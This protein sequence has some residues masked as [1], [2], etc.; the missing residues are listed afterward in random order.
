MSGKNFLGVDLPIVQAP[1]AGIQDQAL[2]IAVS[3]AGGLGSLPCAM[4]SAGKMREQLSI[5]RSETDRPLNTNFFCHNSPELSKAREFKWR[6]ELQPYFSEFG[7][8]V[9]DIPESAGRRAFSHEVAD[10][11]EE[12]RPE[13][14]SFH[15][16]LPPADLLR[17][18]QSWGSVV[19]SSATTLREALWLEEHGVDAIIAQ[20]L[21]AGG[22]RGMFLTG[23][24]T[25]QI[26]TFALLP[27]ILE[28]V[29]I[30]VIAAGGIA[31]ARGVAAALSMGAV[32][33]Q[34]GTAY[35]LCDEAKTSEIHRAAIRSDASGH[36]ALTNIFSG[37]PA[38]SIVNRVISE[39][40]PI[41][42]HTPDFPLAGAAISAIRSLS[43]AA[44]SGDFSPLWCGQ[45]ASGSKAV[46]AREITMNL[47]S[48]A[49]VQVSGGVD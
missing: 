49:S 4:L 24:I 23:D 20:G 45:N 40:G 32:A 14:V 39:I 13:V 41:N 25:T 31:T 2:P 43:E 6:E 15:F 1:M 48:V 34:C 30:P 36:T 22:H 7:I 44:G 17:R 9:E 8:N 10:T 38:R 37:R 47:A 26:G 35:L 21:E 27:Q 16:G 3:L 5:V 18:V 11:L 12:F 28:K 46:S 29:R 33:V 19:L 42:L